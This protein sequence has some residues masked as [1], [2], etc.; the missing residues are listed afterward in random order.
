MVAALPLPQKKRRYPSSSQ[1]WQ[2]QEARRHCTFPLAGSVRV[3][4]GVQDLQNDMASLQPAQV[5][6]MNQ[7]N[8][9]REGAARIG[10]KP[11]TILFQTVDFRKSI[12]FRE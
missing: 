7:I 5:K 6:I 1:S 10:S 4:R 2:G 9:G 11:Q 12:W 8:K 3:L